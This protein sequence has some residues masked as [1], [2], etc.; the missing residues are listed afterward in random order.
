MF[1][2]LIFFVVCVNPEVFCHSIL[3]SVSCLSPLS[4]SSSD[5]SDPASE[6]LLPPASSGSVSEVRLII[7]FFF[8]LISFSDFFLSLAFPISLEFPVCF[9]F[10]VYLDFS[11]SFDFL[12]SL[13]PSV[14]L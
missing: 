2:G 10:S 11:V 1:L 6:L 3:L 9:D 8:F 14:S 5:L 12:V 7:S 13:D 4:W